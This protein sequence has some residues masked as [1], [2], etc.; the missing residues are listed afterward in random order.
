M[1]TIYT[2]VHIKKVRNIEYTIQIFQG[3]RSADKYVFEG[4]LNQISSFKVASRN[5]FSSTKRQPSIVKPISA[6]TKLLNLIL[7]TLKKEFI[8]W[9]FKIGQKLDSAAFYFSVALLTLSPI[10]LHNK[11]NFSLC[12][13]RGRGVLEIT[14]W[15]PDHSVL[16]RWP[17]S[18]IPAPHSPWKNNGGMG[19]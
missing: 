12:G 9:H 11:Y 2:T 7:R 13:G 8:S 1:R 3:S 14:W 17:N 19:P 6:H 18:D 4:L 16:F 10:Y 5:F 15:C